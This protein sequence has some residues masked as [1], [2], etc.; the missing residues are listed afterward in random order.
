L[1]V[2]G[3]LS[4][5]CRRLLNRARPIIRLADDIELGSDGRIS[6]PPKLNFKAK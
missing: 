5:R 2:F 1:F 3:K 6:D 4:A